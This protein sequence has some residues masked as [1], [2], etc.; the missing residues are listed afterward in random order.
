MALGIVFL[1]GTHSVCLGIET[2]PTSTICGFTPL[3]GFGFVKLE[4]NKQAAKLLG[5]V[6]ETVNVSSQYITIAP[7]AQVGSSLALA[8]ENDEGN[9]TF[10]RYILYDPFA[11][12]DLA[13]DAGNDWLIAAIFA[14]EAGHVRLNH[15]ILRRRSATCDYVVDPDDENGLSRKDLELEADEWAGRILVRLGATLEQA[16]DVFVR[17]GDEDSDECYPSRNERV[18]AVAKGWNEERLQLQAHTKAV[19]KETSFTIQGQGET[20]IGKENNTF[21]L[22]WSYCNTDCIYLSGNP[23]IAKGIREVEG[24]LDPTAPDRSSQNRHIHVGQVFV[25]RN[26]IDGYLVAKIDKISSMGSNQVAVEMSYVVYSPR[27]NS[28]W[29]QRPE[30]FVREGAGGTVNVDLSLNNGKF[31]FSNGPNR[32]QTSWSGCNSDCVYV[33]WKEAATIQT[34]SGLELLTAV[35]AK[36]ALTNKIGRTDSLAVHLNEIGVL[37]N[38]KSYFIFRITQIKYDDGPDF[39]NSISLDYR[40]IDKQ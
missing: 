7:S 26:E 29:I 22:R 18:D 13:K 31:T 15:W 8:C 12:N 3:S 2:S 38:D 10:R 24:I 25:L 20:S 1:L 11:I 39:E 33:Y 35:D 9:G 36:N 34:E 28:T 19:L 23:G 16:K 27:V 32:F 6:L 17:I 21:K 14:H 37:E 5:Q 4:N 30:Q 40:I